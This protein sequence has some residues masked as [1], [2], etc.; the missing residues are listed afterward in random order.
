[1]GLE[2]K[3]F[4]SKDDSN[5]FEFKK[6]A[7]TYL[8]H[9]KWFLLSIII[10]GAYAFYTAKNRVPLYS[11]TAKIMLNDESSGGNPVLK[12]LSLMSNEENSMVNDEI[13]VIKS[14]KLLGSVAKKLNINV[15]YHVLGRVNAYELYKNNPIDINFLASDSIIQKTNSQFYIHIISDSNFE[16]K[17]FE[18]DVPKNYAFGESI[19]TSFGE[20]IITPKGNIKGALDSNIRV[21]I[22]SIEN[23]IAQLNG[24]VFLAQSGEGS[25]IVDIFM[26]APNVNKSIDII[27]TLVDEYNLATIKKNKERAEFTSNFID[28]RVESLTSDLV[29][30]DDSIVKFKVRN[31]ITNI[32]NKSGLLSTN[33]MSSQ[34]ELQ[35]LRTKRNMLDYMLGLLDNDSYEMIPSNLG[36]GDASISALAIRYNELLERRRVLL[37][38]AGENNSVVLELDQSLNAIKKNLIASVNNNIGTLTIQVNSIQGQLSSLNSKISYVPAQESKLISIQRRQSIK[39]SLYLYLLQKREEAEIS[40]TTTLPS[41]KIIDSAYSLGVVKN[42]N[43]VLYFGSM[44]FAFLLPFGVIYILNLMDTKIHNKEDLENQIRTM[45]VLGEV[46]RIKNNADKLITFNDRSILSES[47]RIIRTNF[48]FLNRDV[49]AEK[50]RNVIFVTSTI[51]GEGK[52]FISL[53]TALTIANTGKKV[54]LIG[55]DLRN[56]QIFTAINTSKKEERS[57]IGLSEY[58]SDY[59]ITLN[60]IIHTKEVNK[61]KLDMLL[62]GQIPPNPA[63]LLMDPRLETLFDTVSEEYDYVVVDTAPSMLVTDTLLMHKYAGH[64]IYVTRAGYTEKRILNFAK[65]LNEDKKLNHMMLIVNDVKESNFGYGAKYGYYGAPEKKGFFKRKKKA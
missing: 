15:S 16:F 11:A 9:W 7:L 21:T 51:N 28:D 60:E 43:S 39:E 25:K 1:M 47:F 54:L 24:G 41:A 2:K 50:Y 20:I 8:K 38:S 40:Q 29:S 3:D 14:R 65:E 62:S 13:Q 44:L 45:T 30:V 42:S 22:T 46:P 59:D 58:L 19:S 12:D 27:N 63:E 53:N 4:N 10:F 61:V 32:S 6:A 37:K 64:T 57:K 26:S 55:S 23:I 35:T 18:E 33:S 48:E 56:P 34:Q 36:V 5:K 52:S 31:Q 49:K 17:I